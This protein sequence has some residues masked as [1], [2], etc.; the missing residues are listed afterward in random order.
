MTKIDL[1]MTVNSAQHTVTVH[2]MARLLDVLREGLKLTG[3]KEGCGEGECGACSILMDGRIVN[4]CLI[5][6]AQAQDAVIV[7]VEGLS[8][9]GDLSPLQDA[10]LKHNAAQCGFCTPGMLIT[11]QDLLNRCPSP[12]EPQVKESLA[13]NI[14][15]CTGYV[16]ILDAVR[17]AGGAK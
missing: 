3:T 14:C 2:P 17:T 9:A 13:G 7:T 5:P 8:E 15:R 4:S 11:A 6:A 1:T 16:K 12:D 10:F